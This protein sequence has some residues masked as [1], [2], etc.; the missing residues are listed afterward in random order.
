MADGGELSAQC[1]LLMWLILL[2][3]AVV[4]WRAMLMGAASRFRCG[5]E[6]VYALMLRLRATHAAHTHSI[7]RGLLA[8]YHLGDAVMG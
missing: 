6:R 1:C 2:L 3:N 8:S 5:V 7:K 4:L